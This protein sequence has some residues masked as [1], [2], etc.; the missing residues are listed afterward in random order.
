M[1]TLQRAAKATELNFAA[2][3]D[4]ARP[5]T[6]VWAVLTDYRNDPRWRRGVRRMDPTP[7]GPVEVGTTTDEV[8]RLAGRTYRNLGLVTAVDV[9]RSFRWRTTDGAQ[10]TGSR[11][12]RPLDAGGSHIRLE[13]H[14]RVVGIQRLMAPLLAMMLRRN[15]TG[16]VERLRRLLENGSGAIDG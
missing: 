13:L 4:I 12:V 2:E 3:A 1:T 16:D 9:G 5:V 11:A 6:D 15:L 7:A 10:A 8:M 14:V